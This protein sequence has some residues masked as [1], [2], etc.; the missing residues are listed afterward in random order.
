MGRLGNTQPTK[1]KASDDETGPDAGFAPPSLGGLKVPAEHIATMVHVAR[2]PRTQEG[3][4][5]HERPAGHGP[6][7]ASSLGTIR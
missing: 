4:T 7:P 6:R 1:K 5:N 3:T 2:F